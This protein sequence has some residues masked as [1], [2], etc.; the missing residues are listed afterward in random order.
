MVHWKTSNACHLRQP[1]PNLSLITHWPA[2]R[3][4]N[5]NIV[6][7]AIAYR[8][9]THKK[10]L[11]SCRVRLHC[12]EW[13][14]VLATCDIL[15][16]RISY[17]NIPSQTVLKIPT[18]LQIAQFTMADGSI[19]WLWSS[20]INLMRTN[21]LEHNTIFAAIFSL[22]HTLTIA[23]WHTK[24]TTCSTAAQL[25]LKYTFIYIC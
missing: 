5:I 15:P 6:V 17:Q 1:S 16:Q 13:S 22:T 3:I 21:T 14:L 9:D 12:I 4:I 11:S 20:I 25:L 7:T 10:L 8:Q 2:W 18:Q 24:C 23:N 19:Q